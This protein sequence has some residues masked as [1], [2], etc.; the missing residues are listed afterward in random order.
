MGKAL[1]VQSEGGIM[2]RFWLICCIVGFLLS[3]LSAEAAR[4]RVPADYPTIQAAVN[5]AGN[6]DTIRLSAGTY[7][8]NVVVD[9]ATFLIFEGGWDDDG[10]SRS[11]DPS[12]TALEGGGAAGMAGLTVDAGS[13]EGITVIVRGL[14]VRNGGGATGGGVS[15]IAGSG[16]SATVVMDGLLITGNGAGLGGGIYYLAN[17]GTISST[18]SNVIVARNTAPA[19]GIGAGIYGEARSTGTLDLT[20][21]SATVSG[22]EASQAGGGLYLTAQDTARI[23]ATVVNSILWGNGAP[24]GAEIYL[25]ES[26]TASVTARVSFSDID[27]TGIAIGSGSYNS[28]GGIINENPLFLD[29]DGYD[30]RLS[31]D[32]PCRDRGTSNN[33]PWADFEGNIRPAGS[34]TDI[35]ADEF[36]PDGPF[37]SMLYL[38]GFQDGTVFSYGGLLGTGI[39]AGDLGGLGVSRGFVSFDI[40]SIPFRSLV[41]RA[42]LWLYQESVAFTPYSDLGTVVVDHVDYGPNLDAEDFGRPGLRDE[43]GILSESPQLEWKT[44]DVTSAAGNDLNSGRERSQYRLR[45]APLETDGDGDSDEARFEGSGSLSVAERLPELVIAFYETPLVFPVPAARE[46]ITYEAP[47]EPEI[48][49]EPSVSRPFTAGDIGGGVLSLQVALPPF[50]GPVDI[51]LGV[52]APDISP[53]LMIV[54]P[55]GALQ[56]LSEGELI[57]WKSHWEEGVDEGLYGDIPI[58]SLPSGEYTLYLFVTPAGTMDTYYLWQTA[59]GIE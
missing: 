33:A 56:P 25:D 22:N 52:Y 10:A 20:L 23:N 54:R 11:L 34:G 9:T 24:L 51:Y 59:F 5:Y 18:I 1:G 50:A 44:L 57:P 21:T 29:V 2:R 3:G 14:T 37:L 53:D 27:T 15:V 12:R 31:G 8:E 41:Q 42:T 16:G 38:Q 28:F 49:A 30:F 17:G 40:R 39:N 46:F 43:I 26:G 58:E 7:Q 45:F 13:G 35:G 6:G 32:S 48:S 47:G 4:L 19:G 55:N 36:A